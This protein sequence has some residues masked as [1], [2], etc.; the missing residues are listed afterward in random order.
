MLVYLVIASKYEEARTIPIQ[1]QSFSC[2]PTHSREHEF[3]NIHLPNFI[4]RGHLRRGV[5]ML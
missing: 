2:L 1:S 4:V 5:V 3:P